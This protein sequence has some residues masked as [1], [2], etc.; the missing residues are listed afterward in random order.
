M[1]AHTSCTFRVS[2]LP[3]LSPFPILLILFPFI[4]D[5]DVRILFV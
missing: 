4:Q 3:L 5:Q 1:A 2:V